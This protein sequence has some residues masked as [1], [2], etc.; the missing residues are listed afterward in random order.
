MVQPLWK[1][2][3][4]FLKNLNIQLP[5]NPASAILGIYPREMKT[6]VQTKTHTHMFI[7][8]LFI[9]AKNW[10]QPKHPSTGEW[11]NKLIHP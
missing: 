5:Y 10:K 8:A 1:S 11:L 3:W 6:Y 9:I 4:Q 7:A 2:V